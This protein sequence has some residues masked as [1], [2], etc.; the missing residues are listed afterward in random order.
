M[1]GTIKTLTEKNFGFISADGSKDVFFHASGLKGVEFSQLQV[2]D[3]VTFDL[4]DSD[5]GPRAVNVAKA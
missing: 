4:E 2:G 3:A 1:Q 5:K